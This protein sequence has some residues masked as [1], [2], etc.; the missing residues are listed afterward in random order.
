MARDDLR[1]LYDEGI[2]AIWNLN[3][4]DELLQ[5]AEKVANTLTCMA[6]GYSSVYE[7]IG[8]MEF[9]CDTHGE[10]DHTGL[11]N[12]QLICGFRL[13]E[14][15]MGVRNEQEIDTSITVK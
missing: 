5:A 1:E 7:T 11:G 2:H 8:E 3:Q 13:I 9:H 4:V 15:E 10:L 12:G 14:Q 6:L